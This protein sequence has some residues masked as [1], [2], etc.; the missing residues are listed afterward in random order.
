[1]E[2]KNKNI[3]IDRAV[4]LFKG[5]LHFLQYIQS[6]K[7]R[8]EIKFFE[9]IYI[10]SRRILNIIMYTSKD[11][12]EAKLT[13]ETE[14]MVIR[15]VRPY[16]LKSHR[17]LMDSSFYNS[18]DLNFYKSCWELRTHTNRSLRKKRK[19]STK[20]LMT[21]D[22]KEGWPFLVSK[23][24]KFMSVW[25]EKRPVYIVTT[26]NHRRLKLVANRL[27]KVSEKPKEV[28]E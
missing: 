3:S 20:V 21:K 23:K 9:F 10:Y 4:M 17:I 6:K 26:R 12:T 22:V 24:N 1:M 27:G 28:A 7:T 16:N 8:Y 13:I 2:I 15:L 11:D 14:Q 18:N 5:R 25:K 19:S